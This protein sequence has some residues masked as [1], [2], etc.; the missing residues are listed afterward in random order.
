[1][2]EHRYKNKEASSAFGETEL[3]S[4]VK[5]RFDLRIDGAAK[6][7]KQG[8]CGYGNIQK[9]TKKEFR[10]GFFFYKR[11]IN[12]LKK[13]CNKKIHAIFHFKISFLIQDISVAQW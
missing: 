9:P 5:Q 7:K 2:D 3:V 6:Q 1:M 4:S 11:Y 8:E 13:L 12:V 10:G